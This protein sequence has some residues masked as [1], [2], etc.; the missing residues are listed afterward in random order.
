MR[1]I[2]LQ[3]RLLYPDHSA[4]NGKGITFTIFAYLGVRRLEDSI[5]LRQM[6]GYIF[7]VMSCYI[8]PSGYLLWL[9]V[10]SCAWVGAV[11][12]V[13]QVDPGGSSRSEP[14]FGLHH[15]HKKPARQAALTLNVVR[16]GVV[17]FARRSL[18]SRSQ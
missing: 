3:P 2:R 15:F 11:Y 4:E 10:Y 6:S 5:Y 9:H 1:S 16:E 18:G 14:E 17:R 12:A 13:P 8:F 7:K